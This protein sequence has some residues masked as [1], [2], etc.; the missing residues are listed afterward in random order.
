MLHHSSADGGCDFVKSAPRDSFKKEGTDLISDWAQISVSPLAA[1][2]DSYGHPS[3]F[4]R[5]I[6]K[7]P[8]GPKLSRRRIGLSDAIHIEAS[9][10]TFC[11]A[12]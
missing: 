1:G 9:A 12:C 8:P 10:D 11:T 4:V 2:T 7:Q 3:P 6:N 5:R